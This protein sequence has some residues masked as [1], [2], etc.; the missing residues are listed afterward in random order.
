MPISPRASAIGLPALRASSRAS[1]SS[2]LLERVRRAGAA[3]RERSPGATARQAGKA[4]LR[5]RD[6]RVG[7][8]DARPAAPPPSPLRWPARSTC[9]HGVA[10]RMRGARLARRATPITRLPLVLLRV[11]QHADRERLLGQ[12]DRLDHAVVGVRRVTTTPSPSSLDAL[13]VVR[14]HLGRLAR[15]PR[16][17]PAS[18]G[19]SSHLVVGE[20]AR[21]VAVQ[22]PSAAGAGSSVPPWITFSICMPRQ[23]PEHRHVALERA[24]A[25]RDLEAVALGPGARSSPGA[26]SRRSCRDRCRSRRRGSAR[27]AGR[28]ARPGSRPRRRRAAGSAPARRRA[29]PRSEYVRGEQV[30]P[31]TSQAPQRALSIAAQMPMTGRFTPLTVS[32]TRGTAPSR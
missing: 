25:E 23:M 17:R 28:A 21:R 18:P 13:V 6:R 29:A 26:A 7:L 3:A 1:S 4:A 2:L 31:R 9:D 5:A 27:R 14:L 10:P 11:P 24:R 20:H 12:L 8:L 19:S 32:R 15:P 16:A 22:R 30:R